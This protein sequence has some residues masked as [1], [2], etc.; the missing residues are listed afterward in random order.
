[1]NAVELDE[2]RGVTVARLEGEIDHS[3][4]NQ[5]ARELEGTLEAADGG[6]VVDLSLVAFIDSS[7]ISALFRLARL[8]GEQERALGLVVPAGS[9]VE[10]VLRVVA[11]DDVVPVAH[12]LEAAVETVLRANDH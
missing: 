4:G 11:L 7:A 6:L 9:V 5:V 12:E 1:M 2:L 10:R 3:N 8:A